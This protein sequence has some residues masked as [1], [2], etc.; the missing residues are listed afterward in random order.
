MPCSRCGDVLEI[1][2][3]IPFERGNLRASFRDRLTSFHTIDRSGVWRFRELLPRFADGDIVSLGEGNTPELDAPRTAQWAGFDR[4]RVKH[5]GYNPT[6]SYKDAGM[7]VAVTRARTIGAPVLTCASTGNT[8]ASLAVYAARAGLRAV[9]LLPAEHVTQSK[10]AQAV[11]AGAIVLAVKGDFDAAMR[12]ARGLASRGL[13]YL[14]NSL[15]PFRRE[16]QKT[17]AFEL[18]EQR[19]W[20][21][22]DWVIVPG[23]NLGHCVSLA[24]GFAEARALGFTDRMPRLAVAQAA[25][26]APFV[27][28]WSSKSPLQP[29]QARTF[30]TAIQIGNPVSW[31]PALRALAAMDGVAVAVSDQQIAEAR[32]VLARDGLGCEPASAASVA[33]ASLLRSKGV[34]AKNADT[35]AILTGSSLKDVGHIVDYHA[36]PRNRF[37]NAVREIDDDS[38]L[39]RVM[40]E[41][42]A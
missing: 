11:D 19:Q 31:R 40:V 2:L 23:G 7:T 10:L 32:A 13:V 18:L 8:S 3:P 39:E 25:D 1:P 29:M 30:A 22:P 17:V 6:G 14:V 16:G 28:A 37:A 41:V 21:A 4:L 5:L 20:R 35:V 36:D 33:C 9:V 26:A 24:K 42:C 38:A 27:Q 12:A 15:N 34:I